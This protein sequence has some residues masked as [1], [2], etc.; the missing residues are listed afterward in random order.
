MTPALVYL[1]LGTNLGD[2]AVHLRHALAALAATCTLTTVSSCYETA[3]VHVL[4]QPRFYNLV[5]SATTALPPLTLL[6]ELK[7]IETALGRTPGPRFG[8]R[9]ID[10]DLLLYDAYVCDTPELSLPHPRL[11]ERAFVLVPLAEIAPN[12]LH[13]TI[14]L[15][16]SALRDRLTAPWR[17]LQPIETPGM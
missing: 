14:G 6:R 17:D 10:L 16:I 11:A 13:P 2:R 5:C 15:S 4:D 7:R 9:V 3:P 12:L 8:P 1:A